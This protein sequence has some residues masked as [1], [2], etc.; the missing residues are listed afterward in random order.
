MAL[1]D[2]LPE[3]QQESLW[4]AAL[5][6][7]FGKSARNWQDSRTTREP[8]ADGDVLPRHE[9]ISAACLLA[10]F[11]QLSCPAE[12]IARHHVEKTPDH[13]AGAWLPRLDEDYVALVLGP[14]REAGWRSARTVSTNSFRA[15]LRQLAGSVLAEPTS[16]CAALLGLL[17][18]AD[19][20]STFAEQRN[21]ALEV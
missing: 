21:P 17:I 2:S 5:W 15:A 20:A 18:K 9:I 6:H 11:P 4:L 19:S 13:F 12:V 8:W 10:S 7:D 1:E 14:M 16:E 3:K